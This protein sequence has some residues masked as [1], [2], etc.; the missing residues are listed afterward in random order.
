MR[1]VNLN[2]Y[3]I[4][5]YPLTLLAQ[6]RNVAILHTLLASV[7]HNTALYLHWKLI[8]Y[9]YRIFKKALMRLLSFTFG[10]LSNHLKISSISIK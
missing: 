1:K 9:T 2:N 8:L 3:G 6:F 5:D 10:F 7:L 4:Y